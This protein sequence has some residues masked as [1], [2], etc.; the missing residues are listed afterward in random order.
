MKVNTLRQLGVYRK[1]S[2]YV[3]I[4]R[5]KKVIKQSSE[6]SVPSSP[7]PCILIMAKVC[8][9]Y[10]PRS[11]LISDLVRFNISLYP[12][13]LTGL[14]PNYV[15]HWSAHGPQT[16]I[17]R[18]ARTH[19]HTHKHTHSLRPA[20]PSENKAGLC[21]C[22][23][24]PLLWALFPASYLRSPWRSGALR[25]IA[26]ARLPC[27]RVILGI[28]SSHLPCVHV[29]I[30]TQAVECDLCPRASLSLF[31]WSTFYCLA[32]SVRFVAVCSERFQL[33]DKYF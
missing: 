20:E 31:H 27:S 30:I 9:N 8:S 26:L 23:H 18:H 19:T 25:G 5:K 4:F 22:K 13:W 6:Y 17:C 24:R 3:V 28:A 7:P 15:L 14:C 12:L 21:Q 2:D 10:W 1:S 29:T 32:S 11:D 33:F 16:D